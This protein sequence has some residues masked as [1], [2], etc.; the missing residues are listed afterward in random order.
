MVKD[1]D[2]YIAQ[3]EIGAYISSCFFALG[4]SDEIKIVSRGRNNNKALN[5]LAILIREYLENPKY[6]IKVDS[7]EFVDKETNQSRW[8]STLEITLSGSKKERNK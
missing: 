7:E 1:A 5:V 4:N 2:V 6:S 3:K 8:V